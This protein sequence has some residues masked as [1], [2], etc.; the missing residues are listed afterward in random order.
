MS[1]DHFQTL[2]YTC[3]PLPNEC[4]STC[5]RLDGVCASALTQTHLANANA[6]LSCLDAILSS[7]KPISFI[8]ALNLSQIYLFS[9][10]KFAMIKRSRAHTHSLWR[11]SHS[12][13]YWIYSLVSA[14]AAAAAASAVSVTFCSPFDL[15]YLNIQLCCWCG[16][17]FDFSQWIQFK[18]FFI[19]V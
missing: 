14:A 16:L 13:A 4:T 15:I 12:F 11:Q 9:R 7:D 1:L 17:S 2:G 3:K 19:T 10:R 8:L 18:R 5:R 6:R